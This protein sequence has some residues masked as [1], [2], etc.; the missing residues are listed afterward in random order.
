MPDV[1][2]TPS[3]GGGG[4]PAIEPEQDTHIVDADDDIDLLDPSGFV[5]MHDL[6]CVV[7]RVVVLEAPLQSVNTNLTNMSTLFQQYLAQFAPP[8][9]GSG[10]GG[11]PIP[12]VLPPL[13]PPPPV[14][15]VAP[16]TTQEG[17]MLKNMKPPMFKGEERD[18][19][20]DAVHTFLHKWTDLH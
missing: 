8:E 15:H 17:A 5:D 9:S 14:S 12:V 6:E 4:R 19:N 11:G 10:V 18:R 3:L 16:S 20:K 1:N 2:S 7:S 13:V